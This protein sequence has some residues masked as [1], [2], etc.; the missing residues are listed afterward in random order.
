MIAMS[1]GSGI[2]PRARAGAL[3]AGVSVLLS[4]RCGHD[5]CVRALA[6]IPVPVWAGPDNLMMGLIEHDDV[7]H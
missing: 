2:E 6:V 5:R 1:P 4:P 7:H 3:A